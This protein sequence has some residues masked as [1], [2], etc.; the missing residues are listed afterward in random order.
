VG[1][2]ATAVPADA[3]TSTQ[4]AH[5]VAKFVLMSHLP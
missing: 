2:S 4:P 3:S 1:G 5:H